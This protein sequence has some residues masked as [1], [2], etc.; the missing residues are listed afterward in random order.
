MAS[1]DDVDSSDASSTARDSEEGPAKLGTAPAASG[2]V[3]PG[4]IAS[5]RQDVLLP[6]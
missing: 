6:G 5:E 2:S 1:S 4:G 3:G